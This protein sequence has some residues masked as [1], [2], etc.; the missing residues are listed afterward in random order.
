M[1]HYI[2]LFVIVLAVGLSTVTA[3]AQGGKVHLQ[4][5]SI[6]TRAT[7]ADAHAGTIEISSWSLGASNPTSARGNTTVNQGILMFTAKSVPAVVGQLCQSHAPG[8]ILIEADGQRRELRNAVFKECP[9]GGA[10]GTFTLTFNGQTTG[11]L[12]AGPTQLEIP[13]VKITGLTRMQCS[14]NLKQ[15]G[16]GVHSA[17]FVIGSA[18]GGIWKTSNGD[19]VPTPGQQ[20]PSVVVEGKGG[21]RITFTKVTFGD[22]VIS[23]A[24]PKRTG[25]EGGVWRGAAAAG[26]TQTFTI[27]FESTTATQQLVDAI[28]AGR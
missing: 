6:L 17:T 14:N 1:K 13:N 23:S 9:A 5:F 12:P 20:F 10:G 22:L 19:T 25:T 27:R 24:Q 7:A 21:I 3:V 26:D 8:S 2:R 4:D 16:L 15:L 11:G 18:N 28:L